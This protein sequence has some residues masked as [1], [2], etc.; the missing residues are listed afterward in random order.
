M[1]KICT[2][3]NNQDFKYESNCITGISFSFSPKKNT[4]KNTNGAR[5]TTQLR[6]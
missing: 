4:G 3:I 6:Q 5:N 1:K 2:L